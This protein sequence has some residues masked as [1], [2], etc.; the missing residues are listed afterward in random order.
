LLFFPWSFFN[1][2]L[3]AHNKKKELYKI[4]TIS[5]LLKIT[6]LFIVLPFGGLWGFF[7]VIFISKT[8][9]MSYQAWLFFKAT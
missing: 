2:A 6:L 8:F 4:N 9:R 1:I 5:S 7:A 3:S